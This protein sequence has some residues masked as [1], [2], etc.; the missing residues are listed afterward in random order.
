MIASFRHKGI[1]R[2]FRSGNTSGIQPKHAARLRLLLAQLDQ[3]RIVG[4]MVAPGLKLHPLKGDRKGHWAVT[5]QANWRLTFRFENG[6]AEVV[7]YEDY[8]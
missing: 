7:N 2:F 3:A 6:N 5:V 8:H 1:E 4:D